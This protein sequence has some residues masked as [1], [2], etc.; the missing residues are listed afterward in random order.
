MWQ[1]CQLEIEI[2]AAAWRFLRLSGL[3]FI[4]DTMDTL[5]VWAVTLWNYSVV[6]VLDGNR[7]RVKCD[8]YDSD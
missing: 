5:R 1:R 7:P 6:S 4:E 3:I 8:L 2:P